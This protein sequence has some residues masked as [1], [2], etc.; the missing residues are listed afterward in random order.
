MHRTGSV[1][2]HVHHATHRHHS[3]THKIASIAAPIA[4]GAAFGPGGSIAYQAVKHR[5]AINRG[6]THH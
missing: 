1:T 6:L 3:K 5:H 4:V 2:A